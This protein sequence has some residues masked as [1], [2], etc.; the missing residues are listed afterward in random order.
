MLLTEDVV[1]SSNVI[2]GLVLIVLVLL[3]ILLA[4]RIW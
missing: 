2:W 4:K 3:C 1:I